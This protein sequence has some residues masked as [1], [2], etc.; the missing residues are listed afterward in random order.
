V[1]HSLAKFD[2]PS[3]R[4]SAQANPSFYSKVMAGVISGAVASVCANPAEVLKNRQQ[5]K[6]VVR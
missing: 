3:T 6:G 5:A 1:K 2:Q 4:T